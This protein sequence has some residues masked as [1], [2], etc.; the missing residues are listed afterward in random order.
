MGENLDTKAKVRSTDS[1]TPS[2]DHQLKQ[3]LLHHTGDPVLLLNGDD[4]KVADVNEHFKSLF[5]GKSKFEGLTLSSFLKNPPTSK[6]I[7]KSF[8][9]NGVW[10]GNVTLKC[11]PERIL[12]ASFTSLQ[13]PDINWAVVR[14]TTELNP[15]MIQGETEQRLSMI[16]ESIN[17]I[18]YNISIGD[19]GSRKI[20][21]ISPQIESIFGFTDKEY[22][23]SDPREFVKHYHPEDLKLIQKLSEEMRASGKVLSVVYRFMPKNKTEYI[24]VEEKIFPKYDSNGKHVA[25]FGLIRDVTQRV[26]AENRLKDSEERLRLLSEAALEGILFSHEGEV[27]DANDQ[28]A[29]MFGYDADEVK[30]MNI[31]D[32]IHPDDQEKVES[33]I[34]KGSTEKFEARCITKNGDHVIVESKGRLL[35]HEGRDMRVSVVIDITEQKM[36]V[37]ELAKSQESYRNLVHFS[38]N[39]ILIHYEDTIEYANPAALTML[40]YK[41]IEELKGKKFTEIVMPESR[42]VIKRRIGAL[43]AGEMLEQEEI[44][45]KRKDDSQAEIGLQSVLITYNQRQAIQAILTDLEYPKKLASERMRAKLAEEANRE[46][47]VEIKRREE[48]EHRLRETQKFTSLLIE[49]SLD[50][51]MATNTNDQITEFNNAATVQFGY[52]DDEIKGKSPRLLYAH[53]EDYV[54]VQKE[55]KEK[56]TFSGEVENVHK[57]GHTFT[58]YLAASYLKN[59]DGEIQGAMGVS[60][61]IT[62]A[63]E[64]NRKITEQ[65]AKINSI[66]QSSSHLIWSVDQQKKLTSFNKNFS[67]TLI[68][69]YNIRPRLNFKIITDESF[70]TREYNRLWSRKYDQALAGKSQHFETSIVD[71]DGK[72]RWQEIFLN[73]IYDDEG[74]VTEVSGIGQDITYKKDAERQIKDQAAKISSIF[75]STSHMMIWTLDKQFRITSYNRNFA[76]SCSRIMGVEVET[77]MD[78]SKL[79][80]PYITEKDFDILTANIRSA[81]KGKPQLFE[82]LMTDK[83]S[84]T[85]WIEAFLNPIYLELGKI[86][87]ISCLAHEVTE[88]KESE[89]KIKQSLQEKEVLLKEVHHRVKNNLQVI[90]SILNL[91]SSYVKDE[92]TLEILKESQNRIK[93]MSF[94]HESLYQT[95]NFSSIDFSDYILNLSKNL[96]HSYRVY[97]DQVD[98][99]L[100]IDKVYL[101]LDQAIPCGLIVNELVSNSLKYAFPEGRSGEIRINLSAQGKEVML[102]VADTGIGLPRDFD[103]RNTDSLGLQLVVTLVEQLDGE[104]DLRTG[105]GEGTKY[106]I[107]FGQIS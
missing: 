52:S 30:G 88:K 39:G 59:E 78:F 91:Q 82:G 68:E 5:P 96:V 103:Y 106:L 19:D 28:F 60:R 48:T 74:K 18:V 43:M 90:S 36:H 46:L 79:I 107:T 20:E 12:G 50:M 16:L 75:E 64:A 8:E 56:G 45:V 77:G 86:R 80:Q 65:S 97:N 7:G 6:S 85:L 41:K 32:F 44:Y 47:E 73:P 13:L 104:I 89:Q 57:D 25:N 9:D 81:I 51:I 35:P 70:T 100:D 84:E 31:R 71:M 23:S 14:F 38:P 2:A 10:Q 58:S 37:E 17:E 33:I 15:M 21:Y 101:N 99:K 98:L 61:D 24:W 22:T 49:S 92:N 95:K 27:V 69:V 53:E 105:K 4:F 55:L 40:G 34:A 93:S 67:D 3:T 72:E 62:A 1:N 54:R 83:D 26:I 63:K 76:R 66:F 29:R 94:I 11:D 102:N 42:E 87:E